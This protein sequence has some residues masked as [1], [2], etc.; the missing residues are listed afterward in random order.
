MFTKGAFFDKAG[1]ISKQDTF[2][3]VFFRM[4]RSFELHRAVLFFFQFSTVNIF[5]NDDS[6]SNNM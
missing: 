1:N 4:L 5:E 3:D 6:P 2:T